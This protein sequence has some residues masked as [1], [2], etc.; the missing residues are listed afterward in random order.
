MRLTIPK[1]PY[2]A[3]LIHNYSVKTTEPSD[4]TTLFHLELP[5]ITEIILLEKVAGDKMDS[6]SLSTDDPDVFK[7]CAQLN[8]RIVKLRVI[9]SEST[10]QA[11]AEVVVLTTDT[12][13]GTAHIE[14]NLGSDLGNV[15]YEIQ[16]GAVRLHP[17]HF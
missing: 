12:G 4:G 8:T 14:V 13:Y 5:G 3:T 17:K 7:L 6:Y 15:F 11:A 2:F 9:L 1:I 10:G 16:N